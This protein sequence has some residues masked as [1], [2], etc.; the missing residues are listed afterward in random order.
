MSS[1]DHMSIND[2]QRGPYGTN[3]GDIW[4]AADW[5]QQMVQDD[6]G[7][8][9]RVIMQVLEKNGKREPCLYVTDNAEIITEAEAGTV[10]WLAAQ[11]ANN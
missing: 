3:D 9:W 2:R 5:L 4:F 8:Q 6:K 10:K 11:A 7:P 1:F